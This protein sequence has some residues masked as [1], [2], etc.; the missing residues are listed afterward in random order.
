MLC[1]TIANTSGL[2]G[3]TPAVVLAAPYVYEPID[4]ITID[5]D[6]K[7]SHIDLKN[8]FKDNE[9]DDNQISKTCMKED[10]N[11]IIQSIQLVD[12]TLTVTYTDCNYLNDGDIETAAIT[13]IGH[14]NSQTITDIFSISISGIDD[15]PELL[16]PM[17][18]VTLFVGNLCPDNVFSSLPNEYQV[19]HHEDKICI[20][21]KMSNVF[22]DVD[23]DNTLMTFQ[24][25]HNNHISSEC[26]N[27]YCKFYIDC[28]NDEFSQLISY[29]VNIEFESNGFFADAYDTFD[30]SVERD[31]PIFL[32]NPIQPITVDEDTPY[33]VIDLSHTFSDPDNDDNLITKEILGYSEI[34]DNGDIKERMPYSE[35]L[36]ASIEGNQLTI[37]FFSNRNGNLL[38]SLLAPSNGSTATHDITVTVNPIN[39]PPNHPNNIALQGSFHSGK[40]V[41]IDPYFHL[42]NDDVDCWKEIP[43][44]GIIDFNYHFLLADSSSS[45]NYTVIQSGDSESYTIQKTDNNKY[46]RACVTGSDNGIGS[47]ESQPITICSGCNLIN[48]HAPYIPSTVKLSM[49]E[50]HTLSWA[51]PPEWDID[52]DPLSFTFIGPAKNGTL[53]LN[54][55]HSHFNYTPN[56]NWYG[57]DTFTVTI[58][59]GLD[60][61]SSGT[62]E[63]KVSPDN[64]PF[65][66]VNI[67]LPDLTVCEDKPF[68][69]IDL[70]Y[71][72]LGNDSDGQSITKTVSHI[73]N[74]QLMTTQVLGNDLIL[75]FKPNAAGFTFI[76]VSG[77][78]NGLTASDEFMVTI[79]PVNDPPH[80]PD[81]VELTDFSHPGHNILVHPGIWHDNTDNPPGEVQFSY[82]F[83]H[84]D[85]HDDYCEIIQAGNNNIYKVKATDKRFI[86]AKV[87][88]KNPG[89]DCYGET[90]TRLAEVE[91][92]WCEIINTAPSFVSSE[93]ISVTM[94]EDAFP[95]ALNKPVIEYSDADDDT[96]I[97]TLFKEPEHGTASV[98][99]SNDAYLIE[100]TPTANWNSWTKNKGHEPDQFVIEINDGL[101]GSDTATIHVYVNPRN[102]PPQVGALYLNV[103]N[104]VLKVIIDGWN[105]S[106]DKNPGRF[107]DWQYELQSADNLQGANLTTIETGIVAIPDEIQYAVDDEL[108]Q[109]FRIILTATDNG[110]GLPLTQSVTA[111]S[112]WIMVENQPPWFDDNFYR[113][114]D[115]GEDHVFPKQLVDS[116]KAYDDDVKDTELTFSISTQPQ[117]GIAFVTGTGPRTGA[118][119]SIGY[120]PNSD[121]FGED[122]FV[123]GVKDQ[124]NGTTTMTVLINVHSV[125]DPP[126]IDT[127][128]HQIIEEDSGQHIIKF[129]GISAG[130]ENENQEITWDISTNKIELFDQDF[131]ETGWYDLIHYSSINECDAQA[132]FTLKTKADANGQ[133]EV[134]VALQD[135]DGTLN[136]GKDRI[137]TKFIIDIQP[138]ND[139][140]YFTSAYTEIIVDQASNE[141]CI[142]NFA[143]GISPGAENEWDQDLTFIFE[144]LEGNRNI[145]TI[146]PYIT[147]N[148]NVVLCFQP[149]HITFG[150]AFFSLTLFDGELKSDEHIFSI[151]IRPSPYPKTEIPSEP[152]M[153]GE[154]FQQTIEI[155][156]L[157][158]PSMYEFAVERGELPKGLKLNGN[159]ISGRFEESGLFGFTISVRET[160]TNHYASKTFY[161]NVD[162]LFHF[163]EERIPGCL[164]NE[165]FYQIIHAIGGEPPYS[166]TALNTLPF[167]FEQLNNNI[168]L[169]GT[170]PYEQMKYTIDLMATDSKQRSITHSYTL[171]FVPDIHIQTERLPDG[172]IGLSYEIHCVTAIGGLGDDYYWNQM[173]TLPMGLY[174]HDNCLTGTPES[175]TT[176][177]HEIIIRVFDKDGH[178]DTKSIPLRVSQPLEFVSLSPLS[179][180][181]KDEWYSEIIDIEGG[182][183]PYICSM[184][185]TSGVIDGLS[186]VTQPYDGCILQGF[187]TASQ[188]QSI[189]VKVCDDSYPE[190]ICKQEQFKIHIDEECS[191]NAT[192]LPSWPEGYTLPADNR[193]R[194]ESEGCFFSKEWSSEN[195]PKGVI[196][197]PNSGQLSGIPEV[198]GNYVCRVKL[199]NLDNG[200]K[201]VRDTPWKIEPPLVCSPQLKDLPGI[202]DMVIN[203][204]YQYTLFASN[205]EPEIYYWNDN[206]GL[207]QLNFSFIPPKQMT[208]AIFGGIPHVP[209]KIRLEIQVK[210]HLQ[211]ASCGIIDITVREPLL[212]I[213]NSL[214]PLAIV[215]EAYNSCI[216]V[217]GAWDYE[218]T[219]IQMSRGMVPGLTITYDNDRT[220]L[221]G[222]PTK[223]GNYDIT[224]KVIDKEGFGQ[225]KKPFT[226]GVINPIQIKE[227]IL[228]D[229]EPGKPYSGT[230]TVEENSGLTPYTYTITDGQL[231]NG[232]D[233]YQ[234]GTS[235]TISGV[236]EK[237]A[238]HA[239]F[240]ITV[241][242][243]IGS[244]DSLEFIIFINNDPNPW[245]ITTGIISFD[246]FR[247]VKRIIK[248][249][250]G[251]FPL[252]WSVDQATPLPSGLS[253][254]TLDNEGVLTGVPLEYGIFAVR[255][256]IK[257]FKGKYDSRYFKMVINRN[258]SPCTPH[259][260]EPII[261]TQKVMFIGDNFD[262]HNELAEQCDEIAVFD[263]SNQIRGRTMVAWPPFYAINV[264]GNETDLNTPLTF[265]VWDHSEQKELSVTTSMFDPQAVFEG[266]FPAS[267][268]SPTL[269]TQDN[270]MWGLNI[271][272]STVQQS[273]PLTV[274]WNLFSFSINKVFYDSIDKPNV[275]LLSNTE[276]E[277]VDSLNDVLESIDGQYSIL[278]NF[279]KNG[280][281]TFDPN[282]PAF[283]NTLHYLAAGYGYW[284]HM[285]EGATLTLEGQ[286][287]ALSDA[288][289]LN[290]GWNLIG[291]WLPEAQYDSTTQPT[292][293]IPDGVK[294]QKVSSLNDSLLNLDASKVDIIINFDK[295]GAQSFDPSVPSF[296]KTLHY[297]SPGY[298][299]WIKMKEPATL[300]F[301]TN[302]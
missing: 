300:N 89:Y 233:M 301:S 261:S 190:S 53:S 187:P 199:T 236:L 112:D 128:P 237:D 123:I 124:W 278:R 292:I 75:S 41:Q 34:L 121:W 77:H 248:A 56:Q 43:G 160:G 2:F 238:T 135:T 49:Y 141:M 258:Q 164:E 125:N 188:T 17:K 137:E 183:P 216:T 59:D 232:L 197:D 102:D 145:F 222:R 239:Y 212:Q 36:D 22:N 78:S 52:G 46:I 281:Q 140:P 95:I 221:K 138:V 260:P 65:L 159:E 120:T 275:P 246:Q 272:V 289:E 76:T 174:L 118:S 12:N 242:D 253:L 271:H 44:C 26:S 223:A 276:F 87:I 90:Y 273:I 255:I 193:F 231:P 67:P 149:S 74:P 202:F 217:T 282:V 218:W 196:I 270:D 105:D 71:L 184:D 63:I 51:P 205:G 227:E 171:E 38:I 240:V 72:F 100:Y 224:L 126:T 210:D 262:I 285:K 179:S 294:W 127:V 250:G 50:D 32:S 81:Q 265:K 163:E 132:Q 162:P 194:F 274:G 167:S 288:L 259:F 229:A 111:N 54:A 225:D 110:E 28:V 136:N 151:N 214:E 29:H 15:P 178:D 93:P 268:E 144:L 180:G 24:G 97:W 94:D 5:E 177:N 266:A 33:T 106:I 64:R 203:E 152:Y 6:V 101:G 251:I 302:H 191:I 254:T 230:I 96:V 297:I 108:N 241:E 263:A 139:P 215:G 279:D 204:S 99:G 37:T 280:A 213:H 68:E 228:V 69:T 30:I 219:I 18:D 166:Y 211:T 83:C 189:Q 61:D 66:F 298:G 284:I 10:I 107:S 200:T 13:V 150:K 220:C 62:V 47:P 147:I 234:N 142:Q 82:E 153:V 206:G 23:N 20:M 198:S 103:Q 85:K 286:S 154:Y 16:N 21:K 45:V 168:I 245:I 129:K 143:T 299:Y 291:C 244:R 256:K 235:V 92:N 185:Q 283:F 91:S 31:P 201:Y 148:H 27:G 25:A 79:K 169:R 40:I 88:G 208:K 48:N 161:I 296:F 131:S 264:Y 155:N 176:Q 157:Y 181:K 207:S 1:L 57:T 19:C 195:I 122:S 84:A 247:P 117:H 226:I 11:N 39:D 60:G 116:I 98:S 293:Q 58:T 70:S 269:W 165:S 209:A 14:S 249:R 295:K 8:T 158:V 35:I 104:R 186:I 182:Q 252:K 86:K 172:I 133:A 3:P 113:L 156:R 175:T 109:Y 9:N 130:P 42:W 290:E 243:A 267:P 277:K 73:S 80:P 173:S 4:D 55:E 146:F 7:Q 170:P 115:I 114:D 257:D 287:A 119:P 134:T 192:S